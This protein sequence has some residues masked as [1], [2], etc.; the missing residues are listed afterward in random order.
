MSSKFCNSGH[1]TLASKLGDIKA[2][3]LDIQRF[4]VLGATFLLVSIKSGAKAFKSGAKDHLFVR[5][6]R[7]MTRVSCVL[8]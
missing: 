8:D 5:N 7:T 1:E 3:D 6:L 4:F 2:I